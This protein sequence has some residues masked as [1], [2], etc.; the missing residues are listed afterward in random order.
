MYSDK[1]NILQL[2]AL[3]LSHGIQNVVVCPGSRN[4]ALVHTFKEA[5]FKCFDITDERS[6][7]FFALGLSNAIGA[8]VA[9]CCT[10]GSAV[11]NLAPAVAE[12]YYQRTQLL[13][14]TADRPQCW[15][16][17]MDAQTM[18]QQDAYGK[19]VMQS[20]TLTEPTWD[21]TDKVN[22]ENAWYNNRLINEAINNMTVKRGPVHI[23]V[24]LTE[25]LFNFAIKELPQERVIR[26]LNKNCQKE[27]NDILCLHH[28]PLIIIGQLSKDVATEIE[29]LLEKVKGKHPGMQIFCETLSHLSCNSSTVHKPDLVITLGGHILSKRLKTFLR[30]HKPTHIH[31]SETKPIA[32]LFQCQQYGIMTSISEVLSQISMA[33]INLHEPSEVVINANDGN[34][35]AG[36]LPYVEAILSCPYV[37]NYDLHVANSSI[38][39]HVQHFGDKIS[40]TWCNRGVNGIEGSVSAAVGHYASGRA[41][42]LL[43]GDLS[44]FYDENALWNN[45]VHN[46]T[47]GVP[48]RIIILNNCGG[49]IFHSL[50]GLEK[51]PHRDNSISGGHKT[52]AKGIAEQ[53]NCKY[54]NIKAIAELNNSIDNFLKGEGVSIMEISL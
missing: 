29:P 48:L 4:A 35:E 31:V 26:I 47:E 7:G 13:V 20:V 42:L 39:R 19:M 40:G 51:S 41:T 1:R 8:P 44:F 14:I 25:P 37:K 50:P 53:N 45:V 18:P 24:P 16:G 54:I 17:Q 30:E 3:M 32:D 49:S 10:S 34:K 22:M 9:V 12:A 46:A 21:D 28:N 23:N 43:T 2:T 52:N 36:E 6:A 33:E 27:L 11:L 5:G 38:I 15:I